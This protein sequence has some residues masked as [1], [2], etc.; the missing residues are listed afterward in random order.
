MADMKLTTN[1]DFYNIK[2][3]LY[4]QPSLDSYNVLQAMRIVS[5]DKPVF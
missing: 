1:T 4:L 5:R 2:S 3:V